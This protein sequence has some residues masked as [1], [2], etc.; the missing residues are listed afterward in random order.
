MGHCAAG[1]AYT[2]R[3]D[4]AI[5]DIS[6]KF[7]CFDAALLYDSSVERAFWHTYDFLET[8]A[9]KGVTLKPEKFKFC[10][11]EVEFVGFHLGWDE[12]KPTDERLSAIKN[13]P[14]PQS[15]T[16]T[17]I[18]SWYGFVNQ[19]APFLATAPIMEPFRDLLKK[20]VGKR[21]L[22]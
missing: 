19:L 11:R 7:K 13:F 22:G 16:I 1:D 12:Y 21:V 14:M 4:D 17:D 8:C 2:K 3:F 6:R 18:R 5:Q 10:R 20:P 9:K 15:P